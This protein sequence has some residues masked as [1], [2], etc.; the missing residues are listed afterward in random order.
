MGRGGG[1]DA[2]AEGIAARLTGINDP[3][4]DEVHAPDGTSPLGWGEFLVAG[5]YLQHVLDLPTERD[6][7]PARQLGLAVPM[8]LPELLELD[9]ARRTDRPH[10]RPTLAAL[11]HGKG[12]GMPERVVAHIA[13]AFA[14]SQS[15]SG[16]LPHAAVR[17]ALA[18][19]RFYLRREIDV[20]G[21]TLYRLF[22]EGLAEHL[23]ADPYG[24]LGQEQTS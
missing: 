19:A 18:Q 3:A 24:S 4:P 22:H 1:R 11:A 8:G 10:L 2:L 6:P 14:P 5:L 12:L 13:A 21:T 23:R 17:T 15:G 16:P 7:D 9:L 20:D